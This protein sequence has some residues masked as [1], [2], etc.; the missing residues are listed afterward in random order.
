MIRT[1]EQVDESEQWRDGFSLLNIHTSVTVCTC[2]G[3]ASKQV[4]KWSSAG[5]LD[6]STQERGSC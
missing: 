2:D 3:M 1:C 6:L 5:F 4:F